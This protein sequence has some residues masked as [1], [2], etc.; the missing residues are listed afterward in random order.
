MSL[1]EKLFD[2]QKNIVNTFQD[3]ESFG[4]FLDMGLGKTILSLAFAEYHKCSKVLIITINSKAIESEDVRGSWLYWASQSDI[5]YT[6]HNKPFK[7]LNIANSNSNDLMLI[8]YESLFERK[9]E[10]E[11]EEEVKT[12]KKKKEKSLKLNS[13]VEQFIKTCKN[14]KVCIIVDESHKMKDISSKQTKA[15]MDIR[16]QLKLISDK[17]YIYLLTGTPFTTGYIDLYSQLKMLGYPDTKGNFKDRYCNLANI[18]GLL[19]WQQ[20]IASY[21]NIDELFKTVHQYAI[22]VET[23]SVIKLPEQVF[24]SISVPCSHSFKMLTSEKAYV[25]DI[26]AENELHENKIDKFTLSKYDGITAKINNPYY[27]N[28]D[29]PSQN[30]LALTNGQFYLRARQISIGFNG[31]ESNYVWYDKSRIKK[32][33]EFLENNVDNYVIFYNFTPE[34]YEI[35]DICEE[36][37][38]NIDVYC[39]PIKSTVFFEKYSKMNEE[40]KL[41]NRKNVLITNF[42]SGSTGMNWQEYN[43]VIIFSLPVYKDYAQ[44]IKRVHRP[45]QNKTVFYYIF[46]SDNWLDKSM[47]KALDNKVDYNDDM[48]ESDL[49]R[50]EY[51]MR[52][53]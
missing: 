15:I 2:Y 29:F 26:L 49:Y 53:Q 7:N 18:P 3:K 33:K 35:Y 10:K 50:V 44:G 34:L 46:E 48:F 52:G 37:E 4:L 9:R 41:S 11:T 24:K 47:R 45:G 28:I 30:W 32:L 14:Q 38:Y 8:N 51:F 39:G 17:V 20:P 22:T 1:Y 16:R 12:K 23:K 6:F 19:G 25:K 5:I 42:A 36:L 13:Y 21:K 31:N 40:E 27:C 43:K